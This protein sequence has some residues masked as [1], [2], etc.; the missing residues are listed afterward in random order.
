MLF[1]SSVTEKKSGFLPPQAD[2]TDEAKAYLQKQEE[3]EERIRRLRIKNQAKGGDDPILKSLMQIMYAF[4]QFTM[5][6][7]LNQTFRQILWLKQTAASAIRY[8][9]SANAYAA[10]NIKKYKFF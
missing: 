2:L 4:P 10:G 1:H 5:D 6:Y 9:V 7:L 3:N 8:E